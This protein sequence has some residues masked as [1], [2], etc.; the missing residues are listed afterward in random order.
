MGAAASAARSIRPEWMSIFNTMQF[1]KAEVN[2]FYAVFRSV[3]VDD[4]GTIDVT[5]LLEFLHIERSLFS[6]RIFAAFDKDGTGKI[7]FFEFVVS[8][9]KFCALG[10]ESVGTL[11]LSSFLKYVRSL[12]S[13]SFLSVAV[14]AFDLYD[15]DCD[16]VL[17]EMEMKVMFHDLYWY[18]SEAVE[19]A[20]SK[21]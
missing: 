7:D 13:I 6:Q 15:T 8:L 19:D 12:S 1:T 10:K 9:W 5:E 2:A 18:G 20:A 16:G 21:A 4:S 3:D 17:T 11:P 14:F